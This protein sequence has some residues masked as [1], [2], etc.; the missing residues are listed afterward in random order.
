MKIVNNLLDGVKYIPSPNVG[1]GINS[2]KFCVIHYTASLSADSA[3][4]WMTNKESQVSAHLHIDRKG[5]IVQLVPFDK[6]AWHAGKSFWKGIEGLN[7]HS[8]GIELSATDASGFTTEQIKTLIEVGKALN[9]TYKGIEYV[10]HEDIAPKRKSDPGPLFPW[11]EFREGMKNECTSLSKKTT[12][13]LN[14][15]RSAKTGDVIS[16]LPKG[17]SITVLNSDGEW[18]QVKSGLLIGFVSNKYLV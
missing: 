18:S 14:L 5:N 12:A 16:V 17:T 10:G 13:D 9:E 6:V 2:R 11:K 3:I 8:I 4:G 15:R 1:K 7:S